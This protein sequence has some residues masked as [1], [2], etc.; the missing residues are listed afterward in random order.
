[1]RQTLAQPSLLEEGYDLIQQ[2]LSRNTQ[3]LALNTVFALCT[4][5]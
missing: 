2:G 4:S 5:I 1:V 3:E